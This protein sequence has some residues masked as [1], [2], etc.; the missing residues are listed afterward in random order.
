MRTIYLKHI[1]ESSI[2][3]TV[4]LSSKGFK[5]SESIELAEGRRRVLVPSCKSHDP[6]L[7]PFWATY[8][9]TC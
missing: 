2:R 5:N 7:D 4:Y 1:E 6:N 8:N 3:L 9:S